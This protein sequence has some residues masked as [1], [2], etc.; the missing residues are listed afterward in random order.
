MQ[1]VPI[2]TVSTAQKTLAA[3]LFNVALTATSKLFLVTMLSSRSCIFVDR[4]LAL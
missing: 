1:V 2:P 3:C 4:N